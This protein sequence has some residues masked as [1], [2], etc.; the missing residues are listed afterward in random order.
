MDVE[1]KRYRVRSCVGGFW[2]TDKGF[3][4]VEFVTEMPSADALARMHESA[5][6]LLCAD[7]MRDEEPRP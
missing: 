5:F 1:S 2:L 4:N 6:D 3:G 7:K